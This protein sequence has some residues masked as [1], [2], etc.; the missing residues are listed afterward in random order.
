MVEGQW[1]LGIKQTSVGRGIILWEEWDLKKALSLTVILSLVLSLFA[2]MPIAVSAQT[3]GTCG[4][5]LTWVLDDEGTLTVSGVGTMSFWGSEGEIPWYTVRDN[6]KK[7]VIEDGVTEILQGAFKNCEF[8][9]EL[10][11]GKDVSQ[12]GA[13]AFEN[14]SSL[15]EIVIPD[16]VE[17]LGIYAFSNCESCTSVTVGKGVTSIGNSSF[18]G[19]KKIE[20]VNIS[21]ISAWLNIEMN[22]DSN[23]LSGGSELYLNGSVVRKIEIPEGV[24]EIKNYSFYGAVGIEQVVLPKSL[25]SIGTCAFSGC[26]FT[27]IEIPEGVTSIGGHAFSKCGAL[28]E[29]VIPESMTSIGFGA[30]YYC[31]N[32]TDVYYRGSEEDWEKIYIRS[33]RNE[34][35]YEATIHFNYGNHYVGD[36]AGE[37]ININTVRTEKINVAIYENEKDSSKEFDSYRLSENATVA[38]GIN[39]V[40][41][42][43]EGIVTVSNDGSDI[44]VSKE[45]YI[46]RTISAKRVEQARKIYLQR[47]VG[48][49]PI[50][51]AVWVEDT[52]VYTDEYEIG[53][54]STDAVTLNAEV[55]WKSGEQ[56]KIY[57]MQDGRRE[58]FDGNTLT[59][60]LSDKFDVSETIYIVAEDTEGNA[61]KKALKFKAGG[62]IR[63]ALNEYKLSI[64]DSVTGTIPDDI[65]I[66]GGGKV[67]LDLPM[68]PITVAFEDN[69]FYAVIGIDVVKASEDYSFISN[70]NGNYQ[71]KMDKSTKYVF[72]NIKDN[73]KSS[74]DMYSFSKLKTKWMKAKY[75]YTATV[76]FEA[77]CTILGY[78][79]G[80]VSDG[81]KISVLDGKVGI[82]PSFEASMGSQILLVPPLYWEAA[83]VGEIEAMVSVYLNETAKNFTP[84]GTVS[85]DVT[86]KGGIGVGVNKGIGVSGGAE[87]NI[88]VDWDIFVDSQD[89]V[90]LSGEIS[91]YVK[92]IIGPVTLI[93]KKFP[94]AKGI[95]WDYPSTRV[96][97]LSLMENVD[98]YNT[99]EYALIDRSYIGEK[100][101][102][103]ANEISVDLLEFT[104][105]NKVETVFK[106]NVYP[107][108][109][110]QIAEFSDGTMLAAWLDDD[111]DRGA[112][113]RTALM[114]SYYD[115]FEWSEPKQISN[116]ETADFSPKLEIINDKAYIAW[117]NSNEVLSDGAELSE[118]FC[119]W[120]ICVAE[121]CRD[122]C[123]FTNVF[124]ITNNT[125]IDMM[126]ILYGDSTRVEI[127]WIE[128]SAEDI[129]SAMNTYSIMVSSLTEDGWSNPNVYA[130]DRMP[131]DSLDGCI[132]E[133]ERYI[134]YSVDFDG[135]QNDY[136]DKEIYLNNIR[137]TENNELDSN[138]V[139][140]NGKL[141][142][143]SNGGIV[144]YNLSEACTRVVVESISTD[145][146]KVLSD[147]ENCVIVYG[148]AQS[149]ITEL[150]AIMYD[151]E[152]DSRG[153]AT[154]LTNLQAD[155]SSYMGVLSKSGEMKFI[156]NKTEILGDIEAE[157]PY[158]QTD[159]ALF[160]VSPTY[161]LSMGDVAYHEEL[162]MKGNTLE[163][164]TEITN[165]GELT[166][167]EYMI[168]ITDKNGEIVATTYNEEPI[169][170]GEKVDF[171][172]YYPLGD[173]K[174]ISHE[175]TLSVK[176][177]NVTDYDES[178]NSC[179]IYLDY[180]N[181][182]LENLNYGINSEGNAVIYA[183]IVN[184]G[185]G[186]NEA[187]TAVL[188]KGGYDGEIIDVV[189]INESLETLD[190]AHIG[191]TVPFADG[192]VYCVELDCKGLNSGFVVLSDEHNRVRFDLERGFVV[193]NSTKDIKQA[194][195]ILAIYKGEELISAKV[196]TVDITEGEN[197]FESPIGDFSAADNVKVMIWDSVTLIK[198]LI[199]SCSTEIE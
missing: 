98:F 68:I 153:E 25:T 64:G 88:G 168:Q 22:V 53:I 45:G 10:K 55:V 12:I 152:S 46:E 32:L 8:L 169:L 186:E 106:T 96:E 195:M 176:P 72:E 49:R 75:N 43:S 23:P 62:D 123:I 146:F 109:E 181:I 40:N 198:P 135:E 131:V 134:A 140:R 141:Y 156:V 187:V 63:D 133:G 16:G 29:I 37:K 78:I 172:A 111:V 77:D 147:G 114:Y 161:N 163:F 122:E 136:T 165:A 38:N 35:L 89:Y 20:R 61:T 100:S 148:E 48:I 9:E 118:V 129:F 149:L 145:R 92:A 138:P 110:P 59:G 196:T 164:Y 194:K 155:I 70:V 192:A 3:E 7:I 41:S 34:A 97:S 162:L 82:N 191:F 173:E 171:T 19:C 44:R 157:N 189:T 11:I 121:F 115:G 21:D 47:D 56:G 28:S 137:I 79:E 105:Q 85:G 58:E 93:D 42:E 175:V 132:Y 197:I 190:V 14:C 113:N 15:K 50:I 130:K 17:K 158:G 66:V 182:S 13:W 67:G 81:G 117:V 90:A 91:A 57:L 183:D 69:K 184:R 159:I 6:I 102:F 31:D 167:H 144:E 125:A 120:E 52:D 170:P 84:C 71:E 154:K 143:Y 199:G 126:P 119:S 1:R 76:G 151:A 193:V 108:S 166:V 4:E 150:C 86:L 99:A 80:F 179:N 142:Y 74:L 116:D 177:I 24:T 178:D 26:A 180:E 60:V 30:F 174:F 33:T 104:P 73:F 18:S 51:Q 54:I 103:L 107:Y 188:R 112:I 2:T 87:G 139:I 65:P 160:T 94:F 36:K 101:D 83:L 95:I 127:A 124:R 128:N 39:A 5:N 185:Y 27:R